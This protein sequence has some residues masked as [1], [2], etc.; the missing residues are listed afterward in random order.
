MAWDRDR[1]WIALLLTM[2]GAAGTAL[3]AL[4]VVI[5]PKMQFQRLGLL[6]GLAAGLM[7][8][9]SCFDL[10]PEAVSG[11][12]FAKASLWFYVGVGFFA[13][14][15]AFIPEP[16]SSNLVIEEDEIDQPCR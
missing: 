9:I 3:G 5:H 1:V 15:V 2:L 13:A 16:D 12:G 7:L 6:Q 11:V 10:F 14:I 8:S 4:M